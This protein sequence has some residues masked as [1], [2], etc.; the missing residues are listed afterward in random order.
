MPDAAL[1]IRLEAPEDYDAVHALQLAAFDGDANVP[2][3]VRDLRNVEAPL[4]TIPLVACRGADPVVGHVMISH[5]WLDGPERLI[6][7]MVLS[8][9][10]VAPAHQ[11]QG[12]GTALIAEAIK[13][14]DAQGV[15]FLML[16]GNHR[17]YG[18]RGFEAAEPLGLRRPSL[19]IPERAFQIAKLSRYDPAMTGTL[20]YKDVHWRH[21]V[22]LYR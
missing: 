22:G 6:D 2:E 5:A 3:L 19:R 7:V 1:S 8:P 4:P 9:L 10:G 16:E 11:R 12:L 20:V 17:Y 15:P 18:P 21:G 13:A 14:A